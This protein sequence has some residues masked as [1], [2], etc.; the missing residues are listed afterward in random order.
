MDIDQGN[1]VVLAE[2]PVAAFELPD[3]YYS[4][5]KWR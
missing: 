3:C 5:N 4:G 1:W 2:D